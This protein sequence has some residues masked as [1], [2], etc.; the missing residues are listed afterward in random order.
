MRQL[1]DNLI[2]SQAAATITSAAIPALNLFSCSAQVSTTGA[3]AAGTLRLQASNDIA[4]MDGHPGP[5]T[6]WSDIPSASVVASGAG[7]FLIPKTDLCYQWIRAIYTNTG[8]GT[9]SVVLKALGD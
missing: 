5:P 4:G 9:F 6:N 1:N 8:T 2:L 7:A 3:G